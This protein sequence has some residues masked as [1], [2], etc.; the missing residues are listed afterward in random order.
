M[1]EF[2]RCRTLYEKFLEY[3]PA[4]CQTWIRYAELELILGDEQRARAIY[5]LAI[6]QPLLDMPE[7]W[8]VGVCVCV[9]VCVCLFV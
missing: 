2:D 8:G 1:R 3:N 7:V 5:D 9:C 4:N 6:S